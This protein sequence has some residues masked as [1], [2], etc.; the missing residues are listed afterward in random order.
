MHNL[1]QEKAHK[2]LLP[3]LQIELFHRLASS[4]PKH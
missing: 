2:E 1:G 3:K 4:K